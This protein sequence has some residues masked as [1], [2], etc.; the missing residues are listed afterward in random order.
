MWGEF[1]EDRHRKRILSLWYLGT[2][3]KS[4]SSLICLGTDQKLQSKGREIGSQFKK[5]LKSQIN[6]IP[7]M[8]EVWKRPTISCIAKA[9][10]TELRFNPLSESQ[11]N[12]YVAHE[13]DNSKATLQRL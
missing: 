12:P 9:L 13:Q 7:A 6:P 5:T 1:R 3:T 8:P 10:R 11:T 2:C 4:E